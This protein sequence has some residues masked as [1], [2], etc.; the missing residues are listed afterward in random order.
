MA[1]EMGGLGGGWMPRGE[2]SSAWGRG[3]K[4]SSVPGGSALRAGKVDLDRKGPQGV[5][6]TLQARGVKKRKV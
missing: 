6:W 5:L 1:T 3:R 2:G 4:T